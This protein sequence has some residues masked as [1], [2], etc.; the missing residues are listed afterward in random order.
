MIQEVVVT[1][2]ALFNS[3][4]RLLENAVLIT[5]INW[6]CQPRF[7]YSSYMATTTELPI[8]RL[9]QFLSFV[10]ELTVYTTSQF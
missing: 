3:L 4:S 9:E 6:E 5:L 8:A 1:S 7:P 2:D 10:E